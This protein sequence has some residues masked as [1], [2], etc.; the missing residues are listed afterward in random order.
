MVSGQC[1]LPSKYSIRG[2]IPSSGV[3][4]RVHSALRNRRPQRLIIHPPK[5]T[6]QLPASLKVLPSASFS[7]SASL[8]SRTQGLPPLPPF[9]NSFSRL[10][11]SVKT[12][13][14]RESSPACTY[15]SVNTPV[16]VHY[17]HSPSAQRPL[18]L[19]LHPLTYYFVA[20]KSRDRLG[21]LKENGSDS[22][23]DRV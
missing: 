20:V 6:H 17:I 2:T 14:P 7:F 3:R 22:A 19:Q 21:L 10:P 11:V 15:F 12:L 1:S 5:S 13:S 23:V 4:P 8:I 16:F 9:L 18:Q